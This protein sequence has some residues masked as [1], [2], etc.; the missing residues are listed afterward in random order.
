MADSFSVSLYQT[1]LRTATRELH[2]CNE[3]SQRYGL[4]LTDTQ[5]LTLVQA[6]FEALQTAGRMELGESLL[7]RL[8]Y[9][10]CDSPF[11]NKTDY[12]ATLM[13][14]QELFYTFKNE[15]DDAL[16]DDELIEALKCVFDG[17][18][19]GSLE[20][21]ENLTVSDLYHALT[22]DDD[23]EEEEGDFDDGDL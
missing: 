13:A 16:T 18:A 20:Y 11:I 6:R 19:H 4:T 9:A 17:K 1:Q 15:C 12:L 3:V 22:G 10:F 7:P 2:T 14:L 5:I 23:E 21:L 8:V